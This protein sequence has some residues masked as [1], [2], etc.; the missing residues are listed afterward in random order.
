MSLTHALQAL[1]VMALWGLNFVVSKWALQEF[2]PLFVMFIRFVLVAALIVPFFR[3]PREK[4]LPIAALSVTLGSIHFP[5][6]FNGLNGIDAATAS[7]AVQAQVPFS[8]LLAAVVFKD[9]LGW[10]RATGMAAA[11]AGVLVIAGEPRLGNALPSLFMLLAASLAF[12]V[13]SIQM[14]LIGSVNGFAVNGWMALMAAP[15]LLVLSLL[16]EH[17]QMESLANA[18]WLGWGSIVYMAVGVTII[19]YGLWYPL[20]NRY[21]VNQTMPYLL[22]VPVFGVAAGVLLMDNPLTVNLLLGG[23]LT[24]GG[25]GI[26]VKRRP[27]TVN[28]T[29]TNPT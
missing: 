12:A 21:D 4:L 8:S 11:F 29:V 10:R 1:A 28:E 14:K 5:L 18:T 27:R 22:T 13:A 9:K 2:S 26:I 15:Q 16:F 19:A 23:A 17:G 3:I 25:V 24:I 6:M 20:L 7:L